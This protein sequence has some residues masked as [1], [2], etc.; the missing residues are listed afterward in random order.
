[1]PTPLFVRC[2]RPCGLAIVSLFC[3]GTF[4]QTYPVPVSLPYSQNF[5]GTPHASTVYPMGWQGWRIGT[6]SSNTFE[7][8]APTADLALTANS[9]AAVNVGGIHNYNGTI[10][11]LNSATVNASIVLSIS[12]SAHSNVQVGYQLM[13]I[14]NPYNGTTNT[15]IEEATLQYRVGTS[16][17]FTTLNGPVYTTGTT[18]QTNAVTTPLDVVDF[19]Q[20]L[21]ATCDHQPVVQLRWVV[22]D[23]SGG[24]AR[25][26]IAVDQVSVNG[27]S[28][29]MFTGGGGRGDHSSTF[30]APPLNASRYSGGSGRG[31]ARNAFVAPTITANIYSGG[32]GRGDVS[33]AF[34]A[35]AILAGLFS[36]GDGRGDI[37]DAYTAPPITVSI[38]TGGSGR[39]DVS[40]AFVAP[41]ILARLFSGGDGRG[42]VSDVYL[43]NQH[44]VAL[45]VRLFLDGPYD[46]STGSQ[47]DSLRVRNLI[48]LSEPYTAL[49]YG[50]PGGGGETVATSTLATTGPDAIVD[51][52][53][54]EL[55]DPAQPTTVTAARCLLLQRDGDVVDPLT[56]GPV[57]FGLA[58]GMHH[59]SVRHRNHLGAMTAVPRALGPAATMI[60]LTLPATPTYGTDARKLLTGVALLWAG[61]TNGDAMVKYAG[62]GNDRDPILQSIGG[63][64]PT[65]TLLDTYRGEDMNL[66]GRVK[67]AG[68]GNDRDPILQNI[69]GV[70]PTNVRLEQLP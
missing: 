61:D 7:V 12:T 52:V 43:A 49:G 62:N 25:P 64:V 19:T 54:V 41:G 17:V 51:W 29:P 65:N 14:R 67:Y 3:G 13:T 53:V 16:G 5:S 50:L 10:G 24:G 2:F 6:A 8:A 39:G 27:T 44:F 18:T 26:S 47:H 60:D 32:S 68:S 31:D 11:I 37:S 40:S 9:T 34:V 20:V 23:L 28:H 70:V 36:G 42:D 1:M 57:H 66:D 22:R 38:Y 55:R 63:V 33:S 45:L 46:A 48:P 30:N 56:G 59:I 35:P 21:P 58:P 4:A 15:R 69:G